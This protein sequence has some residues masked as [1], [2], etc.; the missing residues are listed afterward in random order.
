MHTIGP[1][2]S[3]AGGIHN[4]V[5]QASELKAN[6]FGMFTKN[7]R[8]WKAK[9][10]DE[11]AITVFK[12]TMA[13]KGFTAEQVL[14]HDSYLINL[15]NP[16]TEKRNK[17][18]EAF[19]DELRRVDELGL[20]L[21]NFHPGSHLGQIEAK[22][23]LILVAQCLD[24]ALSETEQVVAVIENTAGQGTN[25]GSSFEELAFLY[26]QCS[27]RERIGFCIDTCHA[28]AA[29]YDMSSIEKAEIV[30]QKF[31]SLIGLS[32]LKGMHLNDAKSGS[33]SHLD[34]H[35]SLGEGSI[36]WATFDYIAHDDRFA[37]MPL[38]L[39]TV[40]STKWKHEVS[41]LRFGATV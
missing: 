30:F 33:G 38:I 7:Q 5:I 39:E 15:G 26:E 22:E 18:L 40:D 11:Q 29:G 19:I 17:S 25:L 41:R 21:L 13:E 12:A 36:G 9:A 4:A 27:H 23:S 34:R 37:N 1:H 6:A 14:V 24:T 35:A 3:I 32:H 16:D 31:D 8:Q 2:T 28:H 10:L 20:R